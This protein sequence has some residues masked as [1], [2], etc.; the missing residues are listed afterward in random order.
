VRARSAGRRSQVVAQV[1]E[2]ARVVLALQSGG[3]PED[4]HTDAGRVEISRLGA[5]IG[6]PAWVGEVDAAWLVGDVERVELV[7]VGVDAA[8]ARE[9]ADPVA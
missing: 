2:V 1:E 8:S 6:G 3:R 9:R 4:V 7:P 5:E